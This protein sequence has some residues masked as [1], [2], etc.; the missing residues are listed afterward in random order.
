MKSSGEGGSAARSLR[1][2]GDPWL[3]GY[4]DIVTLLFACFARLY[5]TRLPDI[6]TPAVA[7]AVIPPVPPG[8]TELSPDAHDLARR[9]ADAT[10]GRPAA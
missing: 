6:A 4:A 8:R 7:A 1:S 10:P 9:T 2:S 5:V 3:F